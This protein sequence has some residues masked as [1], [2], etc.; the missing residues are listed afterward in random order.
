MRLL[1]NNFLVDERMVWLEIEGLPFR[2][3]LVHLLH[4]RKLQFLGMKLC[5][6]T[7]IKNKDTFKGG[8]SLKTI[9]KSQNRR[10]CYG[11]N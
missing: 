2:C 4:S 5:L 1:T 6:L 3:V 8:A 10:V 9:I 7:G 11:G